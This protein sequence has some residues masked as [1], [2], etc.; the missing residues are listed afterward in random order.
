[1]ID[2][3]G[4]PLLWA[5]CAVT[6]V[7]AGVACACLARPVAARRRAERPARASF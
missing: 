3:G 6:G 2:A 5:C 4:L 7:V 1:V